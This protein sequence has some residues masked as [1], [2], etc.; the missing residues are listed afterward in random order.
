MVMYAAYY[1]ASGIH[2]NADQTLAV[3]GLVSTERRWLRF[4]RE[5]NALL[6]ENELP[7]FRMS[8]F[9]AFQGPFKSWRG[10]EEKRRAFLL[11]AAKLVK[12]NVNKY[13][14]T[15]M[16]PGVYETVNAQYDLSALGNRYSLTASHC[17]TRVAVW[18]EEHHPGHPVVHVPEKGD[19]GQGNF[20]NVLTLDPL[21]VIPRPAFDKGVWIRP[22]EAADFIA[23]EYAK[24]H[25]D[26]IGSGF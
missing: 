4:E 12:R 10:K 25:K 2:T 9:A 24:Y 8:E 6:T 1:D 23:Y 15:T 11:A 5:W 13:H 16:P 14:S 22:F 17:T 7:Y 20:V 21:D 26:V 18:M 19:R 3:V